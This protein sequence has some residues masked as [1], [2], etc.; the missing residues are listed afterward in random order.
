MK[1]KELKEKVGGGSSSIAPGSSANKRNRSGN[2]S[3]D[4]AM[5]VN[6]EVEQQSLLPTVKDPKLWCVKCKNTH[7]REVAIRLMKKYI[8]KSELKIFSVI[9][10]DHLKNY[11]YVE[12]M[13]EADVKEV[14]V[15]VFLLNI[16][17]L[18]QIFEAVRGIPYL[19]STKIFMVPLKE[20]TQVLSLQKSTDAAGSSAPTESRTSRRFMIG[21]QIIVIAGDMKHER[22]VVQKLDGDLVYIKRN[23]TSLQDTLAIN[24][25]NVRK[26]FQTGDNVQIISGDKQGSSGM[27]VKVEDNNVL[28]F[29]D[30]SQDQICVSADN[31][32]LTC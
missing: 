32:V 30:S 27:V 12:A 22:G 19:Y 26:F 18:V 15:L 7:E 14:S 6:A 4:P 20:M 25:V 2:F 9:A 10:L 3:T 21:D 11:I 16:R 1:R 17:F 28:I 29:L 24:V 31:L 23:S 5:A 13:S 8:E